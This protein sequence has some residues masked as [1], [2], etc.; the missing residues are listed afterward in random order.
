VA[1]VADDLVQNVS[2]TTTPAIDTVAATSR[3]VNKI[4]PTPDLLTL[5]A[6]P[7]LPTLPTLPTLSATAGLLDTTPLTAGIAATVDATLAPIQALPVGDVVDNLVDDIT[8]TNPLAPIQ[9]PP[10]G[11]LLDTAP[12]T[13]IA[14]DLVEDVTTPAGGGTEGGTEGGSEAG[15]PG[16]APA[17]TAAGTP[18]TVRADLLHPGRAQTATTAGTADTASAASA[19]RAATPGG[20]GDP[21][22]D[23][24]PRNNPPAR[25]PGGASAAP[26]AAGGG[27]LYGLAAGGP[28]QPGLAVARAGLPAD[29]IAEGHSRDPSPLPG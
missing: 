21:P 23:N 26:G 24:P 16:G 17:G 14:D 20:G 9:A 10:V 19:A 22:A 12:I 15:T 7:A 4:A 1:D 28:W 5:P 25:T 2:E 27:A 18:A 6:L 11:D 13:G 29:A 8:G 3:L